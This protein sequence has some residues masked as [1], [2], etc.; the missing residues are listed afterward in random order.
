MKHSK[1]FVRRLQIVMLAGTASSAILPALAQAQS[2]PATQQDAASS[3]TPEPETGENSPA[4]LPARAASSGP[5]DAEIAEIIV[6]GTS[7]RGAAPVGSAL[8]SV[9]RDQI[10]AIG[11]QTTQDIIR[12][13]PAFGAFGQALVPT[14]DFG[15]V[16]IKPS[17]H[18]IGN[19]ATLTLMNGHRL[20]GAGILQTNAD[21]SVI[22]PAA[23]ERIE[24]IA[25]GAS[26]IYGSDAVAGVVNII[27][28]KNFNG[29]ELSGRYGFADNYRTF[30]LNGVIG[31]SWG[32]GSIMVAGEF[33]GNDSL[34]GRNRDYVLQDQRSIGFNDLRTTA[35][36]PP[37]ITMQG[38]T[39]AYPGFGT[40]PNLYDSSQVGSLIP[41]SR[42]YSFAAYARQEVT[43]HIELYSDAFYSRRKSVVT[44]DPGGI[45]P[46]IT[47]ANPFFVRVPGTTANTQIARL[48]LLPLIGALYTPSKLKGMGIVLGT[49]IDIG[50]DFRVT[51]E[52]N[53][54]HEDDTNK[55]QTINNSAVAA[56]A[57]GTTTATALDPYTG[58]T[59]P[60]VVAG[61]VGVNDARNIQNLR[62]AMAKIDGPLF[63]LPGGSVKIA[64]GIQYHYESLKQS[65][66]TIGV[67]G[68]LVS[69]LSRNFLSQ[70]AEVLIP[71]FGDDFVFPLLR[72]VDLSASI[73]HDK[74]SDVG[75]TTNP[76]FGI[77]WSPARGMNLHGSY[78]TSFR[79]P[80]LADKNPASIDTRVQPLFASTQFAPP[81]ALPSNYFYL[82]G[83]DP[84]L[85]PEK[86][87]TY[88]A[89]GDYSPPFIPGLTLGATW[90]R[91]KYSNIVS[92]AFP[93]ALYTDSSL[94]QYFTNN[95]TDAQIA[96]F[97]GNLRVDGL[98]ANDLASRVA[99]LSGATRMIDLRR[100][101]LGVLD[102]RGIDFTFNY[103]R[104][105]GPGTFL[106][107]WS[108]TR[109]SS[110]ET[111]VSP[112]APTVDNFANGTQIRW[113]WRGSGSYSIGGAN[114]LLA[115][116]YVGGFTNLGV[117]AQPRVKAFKTLDL[118]AS[119]EIKS[120]SFLNGLEL[121]L[122]I[123]NLTD[124]DPPIRFSGNG[125]ST[126]S[127]PLGRTFTFGVRKKF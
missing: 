51:I 79:A 10:T 90:W 73:R 111:K 74:Y 68:T 39:Y 28:R 121:T 3:Q 53:L 99:L 47:T 23:V 63:D 89:G 82:A 30:D 115:Y 70:Y 50:S 95:P 108:G 38:V 126:V 45:T 41:R 96:N 67:N 31:R 69:K 97:I 34:F 35:S 83:S 123:D 61:L 26:A 113:R 76:K 101:N 59:N 71:V 11:A 62:E 27:L 4:V 44:V 120:D 127:N 64:A 103:K 118:V 85:T 20:V 5:S 125:Y 57:A 14:G 86:A 109:M 56:A 77:N 122:N 52:G 21:P 29:I 119:Y 37:N 19:G 72:K 117:A 92:I 84:G 58:R 81:G 114:L 24:V 12:N 94:A 93:P 98:A 91:V 9:T 75:N 124:Q 18:N 15:Q 7:I 42:R 49:N 48:S 112:T 106:A 104:S 1:L 36:I 105:I 40:T 102:A 55:Q 107:N 8:I 16:G 25:D 66:N 78:G 100:K 32:T 88:S 60:S 116:N 22:P 13:T 87:K 46:T 80:P 65:Y 17:I 110:W 33:T 54:G 2:M 6:T 43:D